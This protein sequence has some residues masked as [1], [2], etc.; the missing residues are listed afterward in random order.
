MQAAWSRWSVAGM[1]AC[2]SSFSSGTP[3]GCHPAPTQPQPQ[4]SYVP[5]TP[6]RVVQYDRIVADRLPPRA[7]W[8]GWC[9]PPGQGEGGP[10]AA[11]LQHTHSA[12]L[13]RPSET[14]CIATAADTT[15]RSD[16]PP[17]RRR[18]KHADLP[19]PSCKPIYLGEASPRKKWGPRW[20]T[21]GASTR[22]ADLPLA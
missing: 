16:Q 10:G 21:P 12:A 19:C 7:V 5:N 15:H 17:T 2:C 18:C 3:L 9:G 20:R 8:V 13:A 11:K 4:P 6:V 22:T 1:P 14:A